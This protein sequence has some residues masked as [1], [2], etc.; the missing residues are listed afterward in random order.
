M[1]KKQKQ[2]EDFQLYQELLE[3]EKE[4]ER[5]FKDYEKSIE[6]RKETK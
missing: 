5:I 1:D 6:E 2:K 3:V 4:L